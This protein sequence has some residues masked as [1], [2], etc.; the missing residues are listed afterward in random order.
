MLRRCLEKDP[1]R[2]FQRM[3]DVLAPIRES[4]GQEGALEAFLRQTMLRR[5]SHTRLEWT[6]LMMRKKRR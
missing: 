1:A 5:M 6:D 2:R 4:I 3:P